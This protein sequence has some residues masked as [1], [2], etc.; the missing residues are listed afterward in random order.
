MTP[1]DIRTM[2]RP[3][4]MKTLRRLV[5]GN[6]ADQK[7]AALAANP[8]PKPGDAPSNKAQ[9]PIMTKRTK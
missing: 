7:L 4:R 8:E 3:K 6:E 1:A 5:A 2:P 9:S